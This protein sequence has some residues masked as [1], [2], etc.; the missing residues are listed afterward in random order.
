MGNSSSSSNSYRV[1]GSTIDSGGS[2]MCCGGIVSRWCKV[3]DSRLF[4]DED[5]S[6]GWVQVNEGPHLASHTNPHDDL[7]P[8]GG[9]A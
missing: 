4:S 7:L 5:Y 2:M 3:E 9:Q 8:S 1:P 6:Y